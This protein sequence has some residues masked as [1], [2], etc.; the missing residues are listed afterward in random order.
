M[1]KNETSVIHDHPFSSGDHS[2][3]KN[4]KLYS[5][6]QCIIVQGLVES[7]ETIPKDR[8]IDDLKQIKICIEPLLDKGDNIEIFKAYRLGTLKDDMRPRPLKLILRDKYQV[9]M[10][11]HRKRSIK[12]TQPTVFFQREYTPKEREKHRYL[13]TQL[14]QRQMLGERNLVIKEGKIVTK[15]IQFLWQSPFSISM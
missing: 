12:H 15:E 14:K 8:I 1:Q 13:V 3:D 7:S 11:L 2:G 6:E 5:S 9:N 10:L 4:S